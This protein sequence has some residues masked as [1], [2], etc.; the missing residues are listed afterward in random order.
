M[1]NIRD[2]VLV[3]VKSIEKK[4]GV[5][6]WGTLESNG[7]KTFFYW[8]IHINDFKLYYSEEFKKVSASFYKIAVTKYKTKILFCYQNPSEKILA[9]AAEH[10]DLVMN[11]EED[12]ED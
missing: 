5:L 3:A 1:N 2:L 4:F 10:N 9:E 7:S 12:E 11:I 8:S 6:A